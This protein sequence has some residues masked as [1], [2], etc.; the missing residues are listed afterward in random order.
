MGEG[1]L[2]LSAVVAVWAAHVATG[3][4]ALAASPHL[5]FEDGR[6]GYIDSGGQVVIPPQWA[7]GWEF[8][9]GLAPVRVGEKHGY[10][11][12]RGRMVIPAQFEEVTA[13]SEGVAAIRTGEGWAFIDKNGKAATA[14]FEEVHAFSEGLASVR[15]GEAWGFIDRELKTAVAP[16]FEQA[17]DFTEGL[18]PVMIGGKWGFIDREGRT[19]I[20]PRFFWVDNFSEGLAWAVGPAGDE[21][22]ID[23]TGALAIR[24]RFWDATP[25]REGR[26]WVMLEAGGM[27]GLID[28]AGTVVIPPKYEEARPFSEGL[29]AVSLNFEW[30]YV[31]R[32]GSTVVP[33]RY[34]RAHD[35]RDGIVRV[36]LPE[37]G[38]T[39]YVDKLGHEIWRPRQK[40]VGSSGIKPRITNPIHPCR[41]VGPTSRPAERVEVVGNPLK[42]RFPDDSGQAYSRNIWDMS[43]YE[44]RIYIGHGDWIRNTGPVEVYS[45]APGQDD[46]T[47]EYVA[48]EETVTSLLTLDGKLVIPGNDPREGWDLGNFHVKEKGKWRKVRTL[49]NGVHCFQM[50]FADGLLA[51]D[52][53]TAHQPVLLVSRDWGRSWSPVMYEAQIRS[54]FSLNGKIHGFDRR[55]SLCGLEG[56]VFQPARIV[57]RRNRLPSD[58]PME[59]WFRRT[60]SPEHCRVFNGFVVGTLAP[61]YSISDPPYPLGVLAPGSHTAAVAQAFQDATVMDMDERDG[62]LYVL[63]SERA[64][65]EYRSVVYSTRDLEQFHCVATFSTAGLPRSL[66]AAPDAF[67]IGLGCE[68]ES[69]D[70]P[71][72]P[73]AEKAAGDIL[74]VI[75]LK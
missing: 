16:R 18:A 11:D 59:L 62:S 58:I 15:Q 12:T 37:D 50:A 35:F 40:A 75:A 31:D 66:V 67:Y 64:E 74:R 8:S 51:A 55:G 36:M 24:R 34:G 48:D 43:L 28:K 27:Y 17:W 70:A 14:R 46:F 2:R 29:A 45:F 56:D 7:A 4:G 47:L 1:T 13:F 6:A 52:I 20:E 63:T 41:I 68:G 25:F 39:A 38:A 72:R 54:L 71:R 22:F 57:P 33:P 44:G 42:K 49:P 53:G 3:A 61:A 23:K 73:L 9:D 30:G 60:C 32:T 69:E 21:G 26:A 5:V 65:A 19:V 10:I